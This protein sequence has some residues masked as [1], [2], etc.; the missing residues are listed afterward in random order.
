MME[1]LQENFIMTKIFK[2]TKH[3]ADEVINKEAGNTVQSLIRKRKKA[4]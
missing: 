3:H 4:F 2:L 1:K